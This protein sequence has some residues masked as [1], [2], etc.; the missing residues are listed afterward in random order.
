M[1]KAKRITIRLSSQAKQVIEILEDY[2]LN[3]T[4]AIELSLLMT[5]ICFNQVLDKAVT[6]K[7]IEDFKLHYK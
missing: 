4:Q 3:K 7:F 2:G 6:N 5:K 1:N